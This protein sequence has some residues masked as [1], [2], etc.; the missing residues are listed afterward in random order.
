M[1]GS[2]RG[3][4]RGAPHGLPACGFTLLEVLIALAVLA[5]AMT[6]LV[7]TASLEARALAQVRDHSQAQ[8][9]ASNIIA[10][11]RL[12]PAL[13][14]SALRQG[15]ARMGGRDWRWTLTVA[16]TQAGI[17]RLDVVVFTEAETQPVLSLTGF[18]A[19]R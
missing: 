6:A 17:R 12:E 2:W 5:L 7:R 16:T 14:A 10:E 18:A 13:P 1:P 19:A 11:A 3:S 4:A 15:Q 8:W 9:L